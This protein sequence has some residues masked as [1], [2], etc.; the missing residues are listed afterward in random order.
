MTIETPRLIMREYTDDDFTALCEVLCDADIMRHY[1][2]VFD[3][4]RVR[5]WIS[6]NLER[7]ADYGF[8]LWAVVLK[9]TGGVIGDCGVSMQNINGRIRPEIG[10]HI[11][12]RYQRRGYAT[13]AA[14]ACRDFVFERLPFG[15]VYS[16]MKSANIASRCVAEKNGM[17]HMGDFTDSEGEQS[18]VYCITRDRWE[19]LRGRA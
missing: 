1:P 9:E 18:S 6:C 5:D 14:R 7:Y 11:A 19:C 17:T 4:A 15:R 2:Y 12:R 8:G 13:E 10:Y 16:Y 3:E